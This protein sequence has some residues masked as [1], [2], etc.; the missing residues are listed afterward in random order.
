MGGLFK[1]AKSTSTSGPAA[2]TTPYVQGAL[3][4][5]TNAVNQQQP[6]LDDLGGI[7][8]LGGA[9]IASK[10]F[11]D[12]PYL[13]NAQA[14]ARTISNGYFLGQNPGQSTYDRLQ[15]PSAGRAGGF[16]GATGGDMPAKQ[17]LSAGP[18]NDPAMGLLSSMATD[19]TP[20]GGN[21]LIRAG[22][23][24]ANPGDTMA[25]SA[26]GGS[27][28]GDA[29]A[30][31][32][33]QGQYLN[34]QPSASMYASMM[35][36]SYSTANP[37]LEQMIQ[38]NNQSVQTQANRRFGAGGM[39]SGVSSAFADVLSKNLADSGNALRY[40]NYSDA[41]NRR[42]A[43]GGQSDAA[44][45]AERG[46]MDNA[47]GLLS[48]NFN[49]AQDRTLSAAGLLSGN[50]NSGQ[51]RALAAGQALNENGQVANAQRLAAAQALGG[52]YN[53]GQDR[54]L[55][56]YK[57]DSTLANAGQDRAL[58]AAKASDASQAN[59]I[60]QMLQGLGLTGQLTDAQYA[61]VGP[62]IQA[63]T[64]GGTI[65]LLGVDTLQQAI[66]NLTGATNTSTSTTKGAGLGASLAGSLGS[67][68]A[69]ALGRA[70]KS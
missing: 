48:N 45:S 47:T 12:N 19:Y 63:L 30:S 14:A 36:P 8:A 3:S 17:A 52:Q 24:G 29:F 16:F 34:A 50:F 1:K 2:Y 69:G 40:Q 70:I 55:D 57:T 53:S 44:Y 9:S 66:A 21:S 64:A 20:S 62:A 37:F 18:A 65:P 43:A 59:Q 32:V 22:A 6:M 54:S 28:P 38:Q 39:G 58:E 23:N 35:D 26:A 67:A 25:R 56:R 51:D 33:A 4:S 5:V 13:S 27:N 41:E 68:V 15:N 46:R 11:G 49:A 10:A 7:A 31:A 42:L 61:G 60:A